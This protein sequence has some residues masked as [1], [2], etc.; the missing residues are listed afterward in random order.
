MNNVHK[1]GAKEGANAGEGAG[2]L[3]EA[4]M[5]LEKAPTFKS[6]EV[7]FILN[8]V[9]KFKL[10]SGKAALQETPS[11]VEGGEKLINGSQNLIRIADGS[12][13]GWASVEEY[14]EDIIDIRCY[15]NYRCSMKR[16]LVLAQT[17]LPLKVVVSP[18]CP[19][20]VLAFFVGT[21][22]FLENLPIVGSLPNDNNNGRANVGYG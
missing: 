8:E 7:Q 20:W 22:V 9:V 12:E 17:I 6:H 4:Y 18:A 16:P 10:D 1:E 14:E 2:A 19:S 5:K 3:S 13:H 15:N 11:A 21:W